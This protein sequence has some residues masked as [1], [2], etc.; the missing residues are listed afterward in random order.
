MGVMFT[1]DN[2]RSALNFV[3]TD[4]GAALFVAIQFPVNHGNNRKLR[5]IT[6]DTRPKEVL[7][8]RGV[9]QTKEVSEKLKHKNSVTLK[10]FCPLNECV[11][12]F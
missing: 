3:Q 2:K 4:S 6:A 11:T 8:S 9:V 10:Y 7:G 5:Q 12:D 1:A